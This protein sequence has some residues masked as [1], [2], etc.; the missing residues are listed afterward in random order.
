MGSDDPGTRSTL[1]SSVEALNEA[2]LAVFY[3]LATKAHLVP[4]RVRMRVRVRVRVKVKVRV[5]E[6]GLMSESI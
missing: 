5:R 4:D 3:M 6:L 2:G 1:I